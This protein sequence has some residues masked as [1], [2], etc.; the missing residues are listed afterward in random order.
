MVFYICKFYFTFIA[1]V[2]WLPAVT[3]N[4]SSKHSTG[5]PVLFLQTKGNKLEKFVKYFTCIRKNYE[6]FFI[7]FNLLFLILLIF[8]LHN[9]M[10]PS[11]K[12][13]DLK[14]ILISRLGILNS[15]KD[16]DYWVI[17]FHNNSINPRDTFNKN[18]LLNFAHLYC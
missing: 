11:Q 17:I 8:T 9:Y 1:P 4:K 3:Q 14:L 15:K 12:V 5:M 6:F 10:Y 16:D 13:I 7:K 2:Y 18:S